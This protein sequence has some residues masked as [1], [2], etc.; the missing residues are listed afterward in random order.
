MKPASAC[1]VIIRY[2]LILCAIPALVLTLNA[3]PALPQRL[4]LNV[5]GVTIS[6]LPP[7]APLAALS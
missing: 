1:L 3:C 4:A 6:P 5:N 2:P 7:S